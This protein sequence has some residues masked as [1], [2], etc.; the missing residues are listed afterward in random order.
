MNQFVIHPDTQIGPVHLVVADLQRALHFYG[1]I[2]GLQALHSEN[3]YACLSADGKR[4]VLAL[5]A[6]PHVKPRPTHAFGLY[7]FAILVPSRIALARSLHRL[8]EMIYPLQ[9]AS[10]HLVS[11][12]LYLADPDGNGIEIYADRPREEWLWHKRQVQVETHPLDLD[13]LLAE[14][15]HGKVTWHGL[16]P[17][18]KIGHVHLQ[19][20]DLY[21]AEQFYRHLMGF[22]VTARYGSGAVFLSAGGYHHHLGLNNWSGTNGHHAALE[23]VAGMRYFMLTVPEE[24]ELARLE[25]HLRAQRCAFQSSPGRLSLSDPGGNNLVVLAGEPTPHDLQVRG[26]AIGASPK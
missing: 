7:H 1:E 23:E 2:L 9:G 11:E 15:G 3:D 4:P 19:V 17:E 20:A 10:D 22:E 25:E 12:A 18:T 13:F 14:L 8:L 26:A 6:S 21:E 24:K 16:E 5:S